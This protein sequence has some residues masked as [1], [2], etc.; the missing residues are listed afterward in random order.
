MN[1][2]FLQAG[3]QG[4][5]GQTIIMMVLMFAVIYFFMI[6]PQ[7]KKQ[8][9]EKYFQNNLEK[10]LHVVTNSGIHGKVLEISKTTCVIQTMAGKIKF[11]K[12]AISR[13]LTEF[14]KDKK[15]G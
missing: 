13:E 6:R 11:E 1:T 7:Q 9:K 12:S 14:Y 15:I 10:G 3:T 5:G 4:G 2:I 8:K